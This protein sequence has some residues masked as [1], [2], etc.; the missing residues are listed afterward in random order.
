MTV[1]SAHRAAPW[2]DGRHTRAR[3]SQQSGADLAPRNPKRLISIRLP[4]DVIEKWRSTGPGVANA[5]A[6][7][8]LRAV[9]K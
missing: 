7:K 4:E 8:L 2:V 9:P 6:E 5:H 1:S 3:E